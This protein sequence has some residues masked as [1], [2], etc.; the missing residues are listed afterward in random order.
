MPA[1]CDGTMEWE[2]GIDSIPLK[3]TAQA[4]APPTYM[5]VK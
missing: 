4:N 2:S 1:N 3:A 5:G